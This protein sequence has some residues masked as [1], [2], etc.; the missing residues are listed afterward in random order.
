MCGKSF[1]LIFMQIVVTRLLLTSILLS[2][3]TFGSACTNAMPDKVTVKSQKSSAGLFRTSL[4][5]RSESNSS[6]AVRSREVDVNTQLLM[7]DLKSGEMQNI[8]LNFFADATFRVI[9]KKQT[10]N[11]N[12]GT[13][14]W[15]GSLPSDPDSLAILVVSKKHING[16]LNVLGQ[17]SYSVRFL[18]NGRHIVEEIKGSALR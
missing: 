2:I 12:T 9:R 4:A 8:T 13:I 17:G 18:P 5:A 1:R 16:T 15:L 7:D 14:T 3:S 11:K 6:Y 10:S